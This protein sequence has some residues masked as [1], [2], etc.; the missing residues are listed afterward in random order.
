MNWFNKN[1]SNIIWVLLAI[2]AIV[3]A[4]TSYN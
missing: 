2:Q 4:I 3:I 1:M